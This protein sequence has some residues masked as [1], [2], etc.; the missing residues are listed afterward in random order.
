MP[1]RLSLIE[2][3][4]DDPDRALRFWSGLLETE[5]E[6]RTTDQGD[7]WQATG[8][9]PAVGVHRRGTG[10]GDTFSLPY[11]EVADI[12]AALEPGQGTRRDR[13]ASRLTVGDLQGLGGNPVRPGARAARPTHRGRGDRGQTPRTHAGSH[14]DRHRSHRSTGSP[15]GN[16]RAPDA[17]RQPTDRQDRLLLG[18]QPRR[19]PQRPLRAALHRRH[20]QHRVADDRAGAR[21]CLIDQELGSLAHLVGGPRARQRRLRGRLLRPARLRQEPLQAPAAAGRSPRQSSARSSTRS[22]SRSKPA[23]TR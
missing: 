17:L 2:F 13:R 10:P 20:L 18:G 19:L 22:S 21:H 6:P 7:G 11:F 1:N 16:T 3:P 9:S 8:D 5:L 23:A 14:R 12:D 4:A 15:G